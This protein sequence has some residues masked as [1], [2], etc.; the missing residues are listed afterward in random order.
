[1]PGPGSSDEGGDGRV[2]VRTPNWLG[3]LVMSLPAVGSVLA[4][5][6]GAGIWSHP[7]VSGLVRVFFPEAPVVTG[8]TARGGGWTT[9][10]LLT[11]SFRSALRGLL[12]GIPRRIGYRGDLRSPL[13]TTALEPP[14]MGERHHSEDYMELV[15]HLGVEP[16]R[17]MPEAALPGSGRRSHVAVFP[18]ARYGE[19]KVW[20]GYAELLPLLAGEQRLP[21]E[22][23]LYGTEA[24][25]GS[26]AGLAG[27]IPGASV[28]AGAGLVELS[29]ELRGA[30]L[31]VGNDSGGVHLASALGVPVV[32]IFGSTSP[33]WTAPM[34]EPAT[35][36]HSGRSCSPCFRRSCP[37]G[38]A[39]CLD[40]LSVG[41]VFRAC[42]ETAAEGAGRGGG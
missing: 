2:L 31:A 35:V 16:D 7:R 5:R 26:L 37:G 4:A 21:E 28:R 19:A 15:R 13:L 40:D 39:S 20:P 11:G 22:L 12:S 1:M 30:A 3:D 9:L 14:R 24:E 10:L 27:R 8:R 6:P 36:L 25:A 41:D 38:S 17:T 29:S 32:A 42:V 18:G 34:G 33:A 23:V